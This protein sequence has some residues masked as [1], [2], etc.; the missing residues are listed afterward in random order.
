M[1]LSK[2]AAQ[3]EEARQDVLLFERLQSAQERL[4]TL[5]AEYEQAEAQAN[6]EAAARA[7]KAKEE[8]FAGISDLRITRSPGGEPGLLHDKFEISYIK[9]G[10]DTLQGRSVP[11]RKADTAFSRVPP[12]V[13]MYLIE[14]RPELIPSDILALDPDNPRNA[15][16]IYAAARLR[17]FFR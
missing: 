13:M 14:K 15:F 3:L 17:G 11:T 1:T 7:A 10:W 12:D 16:A 6:R 5:T 8:M 2:L 9:P 4:D